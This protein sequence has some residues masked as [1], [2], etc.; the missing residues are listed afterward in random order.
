MPAAAGRRPPAA[1]SPH[2]KPDGRSAGR[3]AD[4][5]CPSPANR[6]AP[7]STRGRVRWRRPPPPPGPR[8]PPGRARWRTATPG[9]C[10][11]RRPVRCS[12]WP[13][14]AAPVRDRP[15]EAA[16]P[17]PLPCAAARTR[18]ARQMRPT[19]TVHLA[20]GGA[21]QRSRSRATTVVGLPAHAL[22][23]LT[24]LI[25]LIGISATVGPRAEAVYLTGKSGALGVVEER[26]V[27]RRI[28]FVGQE[29][30]G[31]LPAENVVRR[32]APRR[33]LIGLVAGEKVQEQRGMI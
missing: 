28:A 32:I 15:G 23:R 11:C 6:R 22:S 13:R 25:S 19:L 1:R 17:A 20:P 14:A 30:A 33:A 10:A 7:E 4:R 31:P 29:V 16:R 5:R 12:A 2:R 3:A 21:D 18:A 8:T 9:G 26:T 27:A 24:R